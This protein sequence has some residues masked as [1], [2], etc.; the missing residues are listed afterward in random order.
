MVSTIKGKMNETA[1]V[2]QVYQR[3]I[4]LAIVAHLSYVFIFAFLSF[5]WLSVY[6]IAS[7]FFYLLMLWVI[8]KGHYRMAVILIHMEVSMFVS[9]CTVLAGWEIGVFLYLIAISA[10]VYFCP[11]NHKYIPYLFSVAELLLFILLRFLT[12]DM[13]PYYSKLDTI[14]NT[15]L[16]SYNA[17][18]CFA[19]IL[20]AA[21]SSDISA[22]VSKKRLQDENKSLSRIANYD[23]LTGLLSRYS[24]LQ[25]AEQYD[26][27]K[28]VL[29][30]GDIDDFKKINDSYGHNCGDYVLRHMAELVRTISGPHADI[31]RWGGEEFVFLFH[32][33]KME[34]V[35][36][37]MKSVCKE[38][39]AFQFLYGQYR[40]HITMTFGISEGNGEVDITK[41][42]DKADE[43]M[44]QG[45]TNGKN[46]VVA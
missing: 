2:K 8:K 15:F 22:A 34:E 46:Q 33:M 30:I 6:N 4:C 10:L 1:Y 39:A 38:V 27:N 24:L 21:F 19:I 42:I 12:V 5:Q 36:N 9:V 45:K 16:F 29:A 25:K 11:F 37:I 26:K 18:T 32:N 28:I 13:T 23:Q 3:I 14:T 41:I 20:F 7:S 40:L 43:K 44:Y 31:C 17:I 35:Q